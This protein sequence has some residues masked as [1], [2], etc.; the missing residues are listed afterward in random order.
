M[1]IR[2]KAEPDDIKNLQENS[3]V[4]ENT[5]NPFLDFSL[6]VLLCKNRLRSMKINAQRI[7]FRSQPRGRKLQPCIKV[8]NWTGT[9]RVL[10][11]KMRKN[12]AIKNPSRLDT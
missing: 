5:T 6:Q 9:I 1:F 11:I 8:R 10:K 3:V 4:T 12:V 7:F 2:K